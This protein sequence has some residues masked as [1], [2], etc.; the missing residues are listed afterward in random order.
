MKR[1]PHSDLYTELPLSDNALSVLSKRYLRREIGTIAGEVTL[2]DVTKAANGK[3]VET[4][5]M[6][7]RRIAHAN[8][9]VD[10]KYG[11]TPEQVK[12]LEASFYEMLSNLEFLPGGRSLTN[13]GSDTAVVANCI[14]L[15]IDDT[16]KDIYETLRDAAVLQQGGSGLGFPFHL[17]RPAGFPTKRTK[18]VSSGPVSFLKVYD[19]AF[20][21]IKQQGRHG[22]NMGM[23]RVDHPDI[24]E[25]ITCKKKEGEIAN[26]NI[27]VALTDEFMHAVD[28]ND[29]SPW[30]CTYEGVRMKPRIVGRN[31]QGHYDPSTTV[32]VNLTAR[33]IFEEY[34]VKS[35]WNNGEPG[36]GFIDTVNAS[37]PLPG[38]GRIEACNPCGEQ[39]L[40]ANVSL[41]HRHRTLTARRTCAI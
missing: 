35:A 1:V 6:M 38:L 14:V 41:F 8:A 10:L 16:M 7:F 31:S 26:F 19:H 37:N 13:I 24:L 36:C 32:E 21:V 25:F 22:A 9:Q 15:H 34:I 11:A 3:I 17:L 29:P 23:F 2:S 28:T 27:S 4:P 30:I 33:E 12:D 40:H 18:G 39:Y 20:S 5:E